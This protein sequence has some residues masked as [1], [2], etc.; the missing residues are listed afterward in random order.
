MFVPFFLKKY[1]LPHR[2]HIAV[3]LISFIS[4]AVISL[5]TWLIILFLSVTEGLE[6]KWL[7]KLTSLNGQIKIVPT[8]AYYN[9]YYYQGDAFSEGA[10]YKTKT[11]K[12]KLLLDLAGQSDPS[13]M[14]SKKVFDALKVPKVSFVD[15]Y[16]TAAAIVKIHAG[17]LSSSLVSQASYFTN[18]SG[19]NPVFQKIVEKLTGGD[20]LYLFSQCREMDEYNQKRLLSNIENFKGKVQGNYG[21]MLSQVTILKPLPLQVKKDNQGRPVYIVEFDHV[22]HTRLSQEGENFFLEDGAEKTLLDP[23]ALLFMSPGIVFTSYID[24]STPLYTTV[25]QHPSLEFKI[26]LHGLTPISVKPVLQFKEKPQYEPLWLYL[27]DKEMVL[28]NDAILVPKQLRDQE[29]HIGDRASINFDAASLTQMKEMKLSAVVAGF[30]DPGIFTLGNKVLYASDDTILMIQDISHMQPVDP[31][32]QNGI[33]IWV[34]QITHTATVEKEI[35]R[36]IQQAG[37]EPYFN[38]IAYYDFPF[39]KDFIQQF[40]SDQTLFTIVGIIVIMVAASNIMSMLFLLIYQKKHE[41]GVFLT[42]GAKKSSI[43]LLFSLLGLILGLISIVI[44]ILLSYLT[45]KNMPLLAGMLSKIQGH[46]IF[47]VLFYGSTLPSE[48]S[49][50]GLSFTVILTIVVS[51]TSALIPAIRAAKIKPIDILREK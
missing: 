19:N 41:I 37:I 23:G 13:D 18:F 28:P 24:I 51:I 44:G 40:Q 9:S 45:L 3:S 46:D 50:K 29:V 34:D 39:A 14:L 21:I 27:F 31:L 12:E 43:V 1:L 17:D 25:C 5:I 16:N 26:P 2:R 38:V 4:I 7:D 32:F 11:I 20:L 10:G 47:N 15:E 35:R 49:M 36:A 8:E 22:H 42:L 6:T 33:N 48:I 30:Y